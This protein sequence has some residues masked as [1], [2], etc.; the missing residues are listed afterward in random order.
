MRNVMRIGI[1]IGGTFTDFVLLPE[2]GSAFLTHKVPST[3]QDPAEAV[4]TGL[5]EVPSDGLRRI[6][7][8]STVATNALLEHKGVR[9]ALV[10]TRGFR[11]V[12]QIARQTRPALYDFF[13]DPPPLLV[14]A[15]WR[16]EVD[17]RVDYRGQ[18]LRPLD[19]AS[20][21]SLV[22]R[23]Q[24]GEIESVAVSLL[25]S[26]L[27]PEHEQIITRRLREAGFFVSP[28]CEILPEYREYER[29]STTVV[30][31]YVSPVMDRYL[32]HLEDALSG[33]D[34]RIMQSN[35]GSIS[36]TEARR[37]AVRCVLSGPAGGV[38]GAQYV[39]EQA[40]F[41][42]I[43]TFDMGG[44]STDVSLCDG[45]IHVTTEASVGGYPIRVPL[46]DIHTVGSGG[47]SIAYLDLGGALRVGPESAGADPGP[48]CYGKG[49]RP[50]VTDAN[51]VLGRL[52]PDHFLGG[53]M[54]LDTERA[55]QALKRLGDEAGLTPV[56]AAL[57]VVEVVNAHMERALRVISV[58]R[59]YDPRDFTLLS[60]GGAGGLH[61]ADLA[62]RLGIPQVLVPPHAATLSAFGMLVADVIKDYTQTVMLPGD[63]PAAVL[64]ERLHPLAE[65]GVADIAAEGVP[66]QN[67]VIEQ[68]VDMRYVGQSYE[69]TVP[70]GKDTVGTFHEA[71][72][73]AYGY[74]E[75]MAPVEIVNVRVRAIGRVARP[76]LPSLPP[77]SP[78]PSAALL[79]HR[80][81]ILSDGE[82]R[83]PFYRGE[84][85]RP[86]NIIA[87]PAVIVRTDT[88]VLL[89]EADRAVVDRYGNLIVRVELGAST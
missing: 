62:R 54:R 24:E 64:A 11:D 44:T 80:P 49:D 13:A 31:A 33:D 57:G 71:H 15:V 63:T 77:D 8:G 58:E 69:L 87:G 67:V 76:N 14:P 45:L 2:D 74:A 29:T 55:W 10:T 23:L 20:L 21:D 35:G 25:F 32:A 22:A 59:G 78:D 66:R 82:R 56:Q 75:L 88:T 72:R 27:H 70:V 60:F 37:H 41:D 84:A 61:A 16:F 6:V 9:T 85:L 5:D 86:E 48:A 1:D 12:L 17:E 52:V 53:R 40:G 81:V 51:L 38:V 83:I 42:H 43:I 7:H 3:P 68:L 4:L 18:V 46:I 50:T 47:G 65:Q 28:S 36:T 34:L 73:Q 79:E 39:A 30:N 19:P 89:S 26:F